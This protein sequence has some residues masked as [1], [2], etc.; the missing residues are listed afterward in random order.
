[1]LVGGGAREARPLSRMIIRAINQRQGSA[2]RATVTFEIFC[3]LFGHAE[4]L[5]GLVIVPQ[6]SAQQSAAHAG[7]WGTAPSAVLYSPSTHPS[8]PSP[9]GVCAAPADVRQQQRYLDY[10]LR[11]QEE[12][13][14]PAPEVTAMAHELRASSSPEAAALASSVRSVERQLG[15]ADAEEHIAMGVPISPLS[16]S[17]LPVPVLEAATI[18]QSESPPSRRVGTSQQLPTG[19]SIA[20]SDL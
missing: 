5:G 12:G 13:V 10:L 15:I 11:C 7:R 3:Q 14:Q 17:A 9:S 16:P 8:D 4:A 19:R 18:N 20:C 1:M 2:R 6:S